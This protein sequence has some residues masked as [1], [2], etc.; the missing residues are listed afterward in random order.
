MK[1]KEVAKKKKCVGLSLSIKNISR[2][3]EL[4]VRLRGDSTNGYG[5]LSAAANEL[6]SLGYHAHIALRRQ[7]IENIDPD[8]MRKIKEMAADIC[9]ASDI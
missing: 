4:A 2:I 3:K 9:R 1:G 8:T 6:L 7:E 5:N